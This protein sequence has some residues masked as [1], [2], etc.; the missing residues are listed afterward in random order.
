MIYVQD[1]NDQSPVFTSD[2]STELAENTPISML[3]SSAFDI[4]D[5]V[6]IVLLKL[7]LLD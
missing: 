5:I 2:N 7:N 6:D 4:V 3:R 1:T